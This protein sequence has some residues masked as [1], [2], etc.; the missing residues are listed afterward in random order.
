LSNFIWMQAGWLGSG[1]SEGIAPVVTWKAPLTGTYFI[2]GRFVSGNQPLN[3]ASVAV[4][5]N[6]GGTAP[7][8]RTVLSNN[9]VNGF[10]F[11][12]TYRAGDVVQFQV[13]SDFRTGN[14]VG[15]QVDVTG[16]IPSTPTITWT[17]PSAI[18]YGT[19]LSPTQLNAI[20][21][22]PGTF[23]YY[24][25]NGTILNA[26][27]NTLT[28]VFTPSDIGNYKFTTNTVNATVLPATLQVA[29]D[30]KRKTAGEPDPP[31]TWRATGWKG[32]DSA[33]LVTGSLSTTAGNQAGIYSIN[34]G[35]L[36]AGPNYIINFTP[37]SFEVDPAFVLTLQKA[38][39]SAGQWQT[40]PLAT[41]MVTPAGELNV[42][43]IDGAYRFNIRPPGQ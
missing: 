9:S 43:G 3:G 7:L 22:V 25:T 28:A 21:S 4:V 29:A 20:S 37:A 8:P 2:S 41:N 1:F 40:V 13:G 10:S 15:L 19:A 24:P 39:D 5:D 42:P 31:L 14:A 30:A 36:S 6:L 17:N 16:V 23:A 38:S 12:K 33:S 32:T 26:G 11:T 27:T 35:T 18:I 34:Q